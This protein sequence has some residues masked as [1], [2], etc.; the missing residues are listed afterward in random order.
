[1]VVRFV[2]FSRSPLFVLVLFLCPS[3][4]PPWHFGKAGTACAHSNQSLDYS[5]TRKAAGVSS[6]GASIRRVIHDGSR[7]IVRWFL[8]FLVLFSNGRKISHALHEAFP[9]IWRTP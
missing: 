1:M 2:A 8:H 7:G 9:R 6:W 5:S 4:D 3:L